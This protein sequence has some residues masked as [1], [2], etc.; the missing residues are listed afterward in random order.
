MYYSVSCSRSGIWKDV[1]I[2]HLET[3]GLQTELSAPSRHHQEDVYLSQ[4]DCDLQFISESMD[5]VLVAVH[6]V[7]SDFRHAPSNVLTE[8]SV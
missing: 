4:S 1:S 6:R 3:G 2:R 5:P 7:A 8:S